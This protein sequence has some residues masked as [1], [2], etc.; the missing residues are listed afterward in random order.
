MVCGLNLFDDAD[1]QLAYRLVVRAERVAL[2]DAALIETE[3][4]DCKEVGATATMR[5]LCC[6]RMARGAIPMQISMSRQTTKRQAI[7]GCRKCAASA[8]P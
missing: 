6:L 7:F 5:G 4:A 3:P 1:C 8:A 2:L